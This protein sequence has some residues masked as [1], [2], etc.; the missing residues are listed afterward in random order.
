MCMSFIL[1][2]L[3][4]SVLFRYL[5]LSL[6]HVYVSGLG[7]KKVSKPTFF[8]GGGVTIKAY[9]TNKDNTS[10]IYY[11]FDS[12]FQSHKYCTY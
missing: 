9:D 7:E 5:S 11:Y 6:S 8:F 10:G 3:K 1:N 12:E 2:F 4:Y